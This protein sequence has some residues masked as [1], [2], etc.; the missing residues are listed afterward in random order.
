LEATHLSLIYTYYFEQGL[1]GG[2]LANFNYWLSAFTDTVLGNGPNQDSK[3][4]YLFILQWNPNGTPLKLVG[5]DLEYH[6]KLISSIAVAGVTNTSPYTAFST[7]G[8]EQLIGFENDVGKIYKVNQLLFE[9][10]FK[11]KG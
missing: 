6:K 5:S 9:T 7:N 1:K 3:L 10:V 2:N 4:M 11:Y 8:G